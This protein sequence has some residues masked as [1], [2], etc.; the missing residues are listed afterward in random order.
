MLLQ[1]SHC[2]EEYHLQPDYQSAYREHYSCETA[3]LKVSNDILWGMES[4]SITALVTLDL[5]AAL[6]TVDHDILLSILSSKYG[7]KGK[8][9]QCFDQYLR[10]R[11][12]RVAVKGIYSKDKDLIVSVS[13]GHCTGANILNLYCSPLQEVIP[14]DLELSGFAD[15]HCVRMTFKE[16]NRLDEENTKVMLQGC[17]ISIQKWMDETRLK[18]NPPKTEFIYF[19]NTKA[20]SEVHNKLH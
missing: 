8:A 11:S 20:T 5:S 10:P 3:I 6:D 14:E 16:S 1:V 17:L 15:D 7:I 4:Q 9:L 12:F 18:M 2:C 13:Q 19:G